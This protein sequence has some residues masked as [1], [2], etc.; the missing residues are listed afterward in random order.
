MC[1]RVLICSGNASFDYLPH[2]I[3]TSAPPHHDV[4]R[5]W[6]RVHIALHKR[7]LSKR[8]DLRQRS[9][10]HTLLRRCMHH[11][12][13]GKYVGRAE[14]FDRG[15]WNPPVRSGLAAFNR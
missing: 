7:H 2:C 15:L 4:A 6:I 3:P 12:R 5:V 13:R 9:P 1:R 8:S 10:R 11:T 14:R